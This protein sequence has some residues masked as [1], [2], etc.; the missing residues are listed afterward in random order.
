MLI[1]KE[2]D[3]DVLSA[4][5]SRCPRLHMRPLQVSRYAIPRHGWVRCTLW[6]LRSDYCYPCSK[7]TYAV[8]MKGLGFRRLLTL[9]T[10]EAKARSLYALLVENT[11]TPCAL[12]DVLEEWAD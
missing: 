10:D 11:V 1:R 8:G 3:G 5:S 9:G 2:H 7:P 12:R 6:L 4:P